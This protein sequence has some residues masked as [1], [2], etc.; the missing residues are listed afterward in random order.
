MMK[1]K[2]DL[3]REQ[4]AKQRREISSGIKSSRHALVEENKLKKHNE[5]QM[6]EIK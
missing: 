1:Q 2:L 4:W 6:K 5:L 3:Q